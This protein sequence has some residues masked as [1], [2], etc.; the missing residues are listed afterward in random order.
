MIKVF[1]SFNTHFH[2]FDNTNK[3]NNRTI[4]L[5]PKEAVELDRDLYKAPILTPF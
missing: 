4:K 3:P 1:F 2:S 5:A